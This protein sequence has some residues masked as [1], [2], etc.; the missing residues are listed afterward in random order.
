MMISSL[1]DDLFCN[2]ACILSVLF[3]LLSK[4]REVSR[5][6]DADFVANANDQSPSRRLESVV[7]DTG[8][9]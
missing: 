6:L 9:A 4:N 7:V 3:V 2:G 1:L 5:I 8:L